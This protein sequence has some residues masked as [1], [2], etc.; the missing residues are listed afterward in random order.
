MDEV[1]SNV[2]DSKMATEILKRTRNQGRKLIKSV[3]L[4]KVRKIRS[5]RRPP[6]KILKF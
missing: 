6:A 2:N 5:F 4:N 1:V 3:L